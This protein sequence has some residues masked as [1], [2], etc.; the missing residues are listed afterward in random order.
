MKNTT[1]TANRRLIHIGWIGALLVLSQACTVQPAN[2]NA[3]VNAPTA[4]ASPTASPTTT[5]ASKTA[6]A[7]LTLPLLDALLREDAFVSQLK[8]KLQLTD[9]QVDEL[10]KAAADELT[11]LREQN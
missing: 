2:S 8:S 5:P 10:K 9:A 1:I 7:Q 6:K 11:R 3:N 4:A